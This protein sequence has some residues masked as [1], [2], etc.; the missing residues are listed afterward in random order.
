MEGIWSRKSVTPSVP[1]VKTGAVGAASV[2]DTRSVAQVRCW[3]SESP[4]LVNSPAM[5]YWSPYYVIA[6]TDALAVAN[7]MPLAPNSPGTFIIPCISWFSS[8]PKVPNT[9]C[10]W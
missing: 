5:M 10:P 8:H 2:S 1:N 6:V 4:M 9:S 7:Q 3:N